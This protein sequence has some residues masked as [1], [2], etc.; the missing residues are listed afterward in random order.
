MNL[1]ELCALVCVAWGVTLKLTII[2]YLVQQGTNK[3]F[4]I[5]GNISERT[6]QTHASTHGVWHH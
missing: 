6:S 4:M 5:R 2:F 3:N 1:G